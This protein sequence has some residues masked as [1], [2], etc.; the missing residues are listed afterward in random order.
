[1][2]INL[3]VD[4]VLR[5]MITPTIQIYREQYNPLTT[6][7]HQDI[8]EYSFTKHLMPEITSMYSFLMSNKERLFSKAKPYKGALEF[9]TRLKTQG[10]VVQ[11]VTNQL[12]G[13]ESNTLQWLLANNIPYDSVHFT[14]D[15]TI[16]NGDVLIDDCIDNLAASHIPT[17]CLHQPW[18]TAWSGCRAYGLEDVF[19]KLRY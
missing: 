13:T 1:M 19:N 6:L 16:V 8:T 14:K 18:N 11:I 7:Q 3:D 4:G 2:I 10:N 5:D 12:R 9:V 17:I 15:K